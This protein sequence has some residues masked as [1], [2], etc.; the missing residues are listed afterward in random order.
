MGSVT[1]EHVGQI[2]KTGKNPF[3][4][5]VFGLHGVKNQITAMRDH[6]HTLPLFGVCLRSFRESNYFLA[7]YPD[8]MNEG[9]R[10]VR[11]VFSDIVTDFFKIR[12]G[13]RGENAGHG[14]RQT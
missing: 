7:T 9:K 6:A 2:A 10:P 5:D 12:D 8:F 3:Y 11:A 13:K 1:L 4:P 14:N